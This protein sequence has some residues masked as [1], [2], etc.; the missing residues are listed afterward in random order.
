MLLVI[1]VLIGAPMGLTFLNDDVDSDAK[2]ITSIVQECAQLF[3]SQEWE[4]LS[5]HAWPV[6][7]R[8]EVL[9]I[10]RTRVPFGMRLE[11][12]VTLGKAVIVDAK[13]TVPVTVKWRMLA[14]SKMGGERSE[15]VY[16]VKADGQWYIDAEVMMKWQP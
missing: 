2:Q 3:D 6:E 15:M 9:R 5:K 16:M 14:L 1:V 4:D 10:F 7:K 12:P 13:A 11:L 8:D